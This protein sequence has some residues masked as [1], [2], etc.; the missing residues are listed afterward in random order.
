MVLDRSEAAQRPDQVTREH[1]RSAEPE[2]RGAPRIIA[3]SAKR[4]GFA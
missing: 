1:L 3:G 2:L 4:R